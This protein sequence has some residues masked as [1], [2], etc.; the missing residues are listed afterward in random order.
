MRYHGNYC[1]PNWSGGLHQPSVVSDVEAIDEFDETCKVHDEAYALNRNLR[2]ADLT[3]ASENLRSL[4]GKRMLAGLVV[5]LQGLARPPDIT[6][7]PTNEPVMSQNR[8]KTGNLRMQGK[9]KSSSAKKGNSG[10]PNGSMTAAPVALA[11]RRT[12]KTPA[13]SSSGTM[14]T[15]SHRAFLGPISNDPNY[16]VNTFQTNP[17]LADTFPWLSALASRYD[18]YR[19]RKLRFEYRSVTAT[20]KAGIMMMSFD[21]NASDVPPSSKIIQAQTIPNSENNVWISN[22]LVVPCD[23]QWRFVRQ[24]LI[25]NTDIKTYDLGVMH[26]SSQYGDGLIGGE[27]YVEYTVELEKPS[28]PS[29]IAMLLSAAGPAVAA[30]LGTSPSIFTNGAPFRHVSA[31]TLACTVGGV[32]IFSVEANGTG[33]TDLA[34]PTIASLSGGTVVQLEAE[35]I[36]TASTR[37]IHIY[38]VICGRGDVLTYSSTVAATTLAGYKLYIAPWF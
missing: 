9:P 30:P 6:N 13:V 16:T 35:T 22:E 38:R 32:W 28:E 31:T 25:P 12:G 3:F 27:L 29:N 7:I 37:G 2:E 14:T 8:T 1:G 19:F 23:N 20:S 24:T 4:V 5:G 11:T 36:N 15:V 33:I 21:Y 26:L 18:K 34:S 10:A 17:G